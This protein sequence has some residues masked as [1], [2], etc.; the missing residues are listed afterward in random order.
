MK[1]PL[2]WLNELV[3]DLPE[4]DELV[5]TLIGIGLEVDNVSTLPG[6]PKNVIVEDIL[7]S[8]PIPGREHLVV[9]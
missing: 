4:V 9:A 8:Q 2:E 6:A 3:N 7:K 5:E 1:L